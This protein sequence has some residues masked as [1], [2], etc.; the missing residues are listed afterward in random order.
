MLEN[1]NKPQIINVLISVGMA[2]GIL[3]VLVLQ[4]SQSKKIDEL[5]EGFFSEG[6]ITYNQLAEDVFTTVELELEDGST[7]K[8]KV[9][10]GTV[11]GGLLVGRLELETEGG[12]VIKGIV[13]EYVLTPIEIENGSITEE[14]LARVLIERI[15]Q[16]EDSSEEGSADEEE[17]TSTT[18][19]TD[20]SII[21]VKL[22]D[23][24][25]TTAKLADGS[26][27]TIKIVDASI[28]SGKIQD[29][30]ILTKHLGSSSVTS[31]K[32][33]DGT[34]VNADI[35]G[36]AAIAY[37]KLNLTGSLLLG[38]L[39]Q[40]GC[41]DEQVIKWDNGGSTWACASDT[42]TNT[43][44]NESQVEGY[45]TNGAIDLFTGST[46]N[47]QALATES[48]VTGLGYITDG[49]TGWDNSYGFITGS[50]T[51]AL[52]NKS[53]NISMW[54]NDSSYL[55]SFTE[56]DPTLTNDGTVILGSGSVSPV[57][58]TFNADG[59]TDGTI[60]WSGVSDV[61][62]TNGS[63]LAGN[64]SNTGFGPATC[65]TGMIPV[66]PSNGRNGFCVDKYEAKQS[67][68]VAVSQASGAPWATIAQYDARKACIVAGKHLITEAEWIQIA[69][70]VEQ[71]GWNWNGG[72]VGTN[73]MSDGHSDNVPASALVADITGDPDD[74]P[75]VNTGQTCNLTTWNTQ[76]RTYKLGNGEYIW[77]FGG[78]VW[79]WVDAFT[80][81]N[82]P[83]ANNWSAWAACTN[84]DGI[85]GN[86]IV[87][88]DQRYGGNIVD[89][90]AVVRGGRWAY[91]TNAGAFSLDL[92][93]VPSYTS[94]GLGFRC[95]R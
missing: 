32:I 7:S 68:S 95:A 92:S 24:A 71:V 48:W 44:L 72:V 74:D 81:A 89:L 36:T 67:G 79:D 47:S 54:T 50:S 80:Y 55:T 8:A 25:V 26:V 84:P 35:S 28:T 83:I 9:L 18:G 5:K 82:Y 6:S 63:F 17:S 61:F 21:T 39:G 12:E 73:Y 43:Q 91:G 29:A 13:T 70:D 64:G 94:T 53:G 16:L 33:V 57:T 11:Q 69:Q 45:I 4:V 93:D 87:T 62:E 86:T 46:M 60:T 27:T 30:V 3:T 38:D 66:P 90:R 2:L 1:K 49:N 85:C 65:P 78:N 56:T 41:T 14:K 22:A 10:S 88:N 52:T 15:E 20:G 76:R 42:D 19:I 34:I 58:L 37:S 31:V 75:C 40:N 59:G 77:D 23:E 51:E